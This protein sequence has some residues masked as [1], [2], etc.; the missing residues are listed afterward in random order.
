MKEQIR[1]EFYYRAFDKTTAYR[2]MWQADPEIARAI[3][4][5]PKAQSLLAGANKVYAMRQ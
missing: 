4:S 1:F 5:L 3:E 2:A